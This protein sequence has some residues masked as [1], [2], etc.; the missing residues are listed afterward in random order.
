MRDFP[1]DIGTRRGYRRRS[2]V[3][4]VPATITARPRYHPRGATS[5]GISAAKRIRGMTASGKRQRAGG[6]R[7]GRVAWHGGANICWYDTHRRCEK[8]GRSLGGQECTHTTSKH[9]TLRHRFIDRRCRHA[10]RNT[11]AVV[12]THTHTHAEHGRAPLHT[13]VYTHA[14]VMQH[15]RR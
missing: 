11:D 4:V 5:R 1:R 15:A 2:V 10:S 9:S 6:R 12:H 8:R 3:V 7:A 14:H 13:H